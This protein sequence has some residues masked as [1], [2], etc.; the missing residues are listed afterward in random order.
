MSQF[1]DR[2][3]AVLRQLIHDYRDGML[4][5]NVLIQRIEG[6]GDVLGVEEWKDGVFPIVL[7]LEQINAAALNA[8]RGLTSA[9]KASIDSS[10]LDVEALIKRL[11]IEGVETKDSSA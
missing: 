3:A 5:L 6:V 4:G 10:L 11:E 2:Q 8:K 1:F 7:S 9:D